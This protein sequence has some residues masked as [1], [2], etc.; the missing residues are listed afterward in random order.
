[1]Y[2]FI[3]NLKYYGF[4][5]ASRLCDVVRF[6]SDILVFKSKILNVWQSH[7]WTK[8]Y[9]CNQ[10]P[11]PLKYLLQNSI[12]GRS[13]RSLWGKFFKRLYCAQEDIDF[14]FLEQN[15]MQ[16]VKAG[17]CNERNGFQN[18]YYIFERY[19]ASIYTPKSIVCD[20]SS[21]T[22]FRSFNMKTFLKKWEPLPKLGSIFIVFQ[23]TSRENYT[24][25]YCR[26]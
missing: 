14:K 15:S 1:M 13:T 6:N 20:T 26:F 18:S 7:T 3:L 19:A 17:Q 24:G 25:L 9:I 11:I 22:S 23:I 5:L 8:S 16:A 21:Q 4:H 2:I 12:L 10:N